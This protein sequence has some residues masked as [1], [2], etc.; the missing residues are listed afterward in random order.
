MQNLHF[1]ST[2]HIH[3]KDQNGYHIQ[4]IYIVY[5]GV[6]VLLHNIILHIP[7]TSYENKNNFTKHKKTEKIQQKT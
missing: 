1:R 6:S 4:H 3:C 7:N 2:N 5:D